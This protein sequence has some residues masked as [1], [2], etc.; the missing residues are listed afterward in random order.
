MGWD[1]QRQAARERQA[2]TK[3]GQRGR[4]TAC[5]NAP[6]RARGTA[7]A[8]PS[9][10]SPRPRQ[11]R[12]IPP[13][14]PRLAGTPVVR[15]VRRQQWP[16]AELKGGS[17]P[18]AQRNN[19]GPPWC[20]V[21]PSQNINEETTHLGRHGLANAGHKRPHAS[22]AEIVHLWGKTWQRHGS[23]PRD[24]RRSTGRPRGKGQ[25][26]A[27][28]DAP[29]AAKGVLAR[30]LQTEAALVADAKDDN[31]AGMHILEKLGQ[32]CGR[33]AVMAAGD[34]PAARAALSG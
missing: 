5:G 18:R 4:P 19:R 32:P 7:A 6:C 11:A 13:A 31:A 30:V 29:H 15:R 34:G 2:T 3:A 20:T 25:G 9:R 10:M 21:A 14:S 16:K 27:Y 26:R 17:V 23:W 33:K 24:A 22:P 28:V 1:G 8:P 12:P